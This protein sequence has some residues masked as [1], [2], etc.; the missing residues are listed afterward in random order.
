MGFS[1][2]II[3]VPTTS[4]AFSTNNNQPT[5]TN[6]N[7]TIQCMACRCSSSYQGGPDLLLTKVQKDSLLL[8]S[9]PGKQW[10]IDILFFKD[11]TIITKYYCTQFTIMRP[12]SFEDIPACVRIDAACYPS[13]VREGVELFHHFWNQYVCV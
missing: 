1:F 2:R 4:A 6:I 8:Y 11:A 5:T 9:W 7:N 13:P 10:N 3:E 12:I